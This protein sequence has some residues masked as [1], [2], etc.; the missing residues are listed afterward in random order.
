MA[1]RHAAD[2]FHHEPETRRWIDEYI[3]DGEHLWDIGANVGLY[4]LYAALR[5]GVTVTSF[6]PVAATFAQLTENIA[7]TELTERVV[8]LCIALSSRS[9]VAPLYLA[10]VEPAA[11]MHSLGTPQN[12]EGP[13]DPVRKQQVPAFRGDDLLRQLRLSAPQ[14][15]KIDV[16]GHELSVLEGLGNLLDQIRTVCIEVEGGDTAIQ[17]F[18]MEHEFEME[19]SYGGRN[20]LFLNKKS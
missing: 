15:L 8:P 3:R 14:H 20:R 4:S 19:P 5:A 12:V 9:G 2:F 7:L 17:Q 16:D 13:F 6:E 18:L 10:S 1:A 11:A